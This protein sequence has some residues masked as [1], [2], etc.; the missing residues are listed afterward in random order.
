M[1]GLISTQ[2]YGRTGQVNNP[3]FSV[4]K[5]S[6]QNNVSAGEHTLTWEETKFMRGGCQQPSTTNITV[7]LSGLYEIIIHVQ[8]N[9]MNFEANYFDIRFY[10]DNSTYNQFFYSE[11]HEKGKIDSL[12]SSTI[13]DLSKGASLDVRLYIDA[14][15]AISG[16]VHINSTT[17]IAGGDQ[18]TFFSGRYLGH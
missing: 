6:S 4:R 1:A 13:V 5:T 15:G 18:G 17:D 8:L 2:N 12:F 9:Q 7:P 14:V 3:A 10:I 16:G 11:P